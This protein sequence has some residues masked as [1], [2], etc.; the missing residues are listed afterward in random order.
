MQRELGKLHKN[1]QRKKKRY[2]LQPHRNKT[3][4]HQSDLPSNCYHLTWLSAEVTA[5]VSLVFRNT[6]PV[7]HFLGDISTLLFP[8][9]PCPP[10]TSVLELTRPP[11][12][13]TSLQSPKSWEGAPRLSE[14]SV[15]G[16]SGIND[17]CTG[18][19]M[20]TQ[21]WVHRLWIWLNSN[22]KD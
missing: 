12:A 3:T 14:K 19:R 17:I 7:S 6:S 1:E 16:S 20:F 21:V 13:R 4:L 2:P 5:H 18:E 15:L 8:A 10:R 22:K 11:C 9:L